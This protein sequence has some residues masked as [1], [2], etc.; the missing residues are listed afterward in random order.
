MNAKVSVIVPVYGTEQ[1]LRKCLDSLV[2]QTLQEIEIIV[3]NDGSLD[4]SQQIIEEYES[5]Y[6][7]VHGI[8]KENGGLSDARNCG[9]QY[10]SGEFI[11][12]VDSDDYVE[13]HMY[14]LMYERAIKDALDIVVCD[15][16]MDYPTHS[17][18][19]KA[20]LGYANVPDKAYVFAY[21]NAPAR[22]V[23]ATFM[24]EHMFRKG[25]WYEDLDLMPTLAV[26]TTKIGFIH[27]ALYHYLQRDASIMNQTAFHSK[28]EDI[29]TVLQD[30]SDAFEEHGKYET[31]YS[32]LEY[33]YIIHLQRS[34]ILRFSG[35]KG[36]E[37][38]RKKVHQIMKYKFPNWSKNPYFKKSG[39]KF[40]LICLLGAWKQ[41]WIITLL[42]K[43]V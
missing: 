41:Y 33:L 36:A 40:R 2:E 28:F 12:F 38:C 42:K 17:Y 30:V 25:I 32:E 18:V 11:A 6:S 3:V 20:D 22:L 27:E 26:Y 39:W 21:P 8:Q 29:F 14:E 7:K 19:L 4:N 31:Y 9:I 1:Y 43:V 10:A 15:T 24:K 37:H 35:I 23:R 5:K 34:A 16:F 13:S